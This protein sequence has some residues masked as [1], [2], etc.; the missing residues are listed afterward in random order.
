MENI[1]TKLFILHGY[2]NTSDTDGVSVLGAGPNIGPLQEKLQEIK[3]NNAADFVKLH[4]GELEISESNCMYEVIDEYG[5]YAK[6]YIT[7]E[8]IPIKSEY[9]YCAFVW[10]KNRQ[11]M[12]PEGRPV[13]TEYLCRERLNEK[14]EK[15]WLPEYLDDSRVQIRKRSVSTI[16][17]S[18]EVIE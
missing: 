8:E 5:G 18:W 10:N 13:G 12:W 11:E 16:N 2:W 3:S 17:G 15:G 4:D 9:E 14:I 7:E 6:F 1:G